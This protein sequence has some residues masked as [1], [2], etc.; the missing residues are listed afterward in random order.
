MLLR[1]ALPALLVS[2]LACGT[3]ESEPEDDDVQ[4]AEQ[5]STGADTS[6]DL[7][8]VS[9]LL[10][11]PP[12]EIGPSARGAASEPECVTVE[13]DGLTYAEVTFSDCL[14]AGGNL[15]VDG[16]VRADLSADALE[17]LV[18]DVTTTGLIVGQ[19]TVTGAWQVRDPF[20]PAAPMSW[21]GH[22]DITG[23]YGHTVSLATTASW[24]ND[25]ACTTLIE[26]D[27][28]YGLATV[29]AD[30]VHRCAGACADRGSVSVTFLGATLQWTYNG[31]GS[32]TVT[33]GR[34]KSFVMQLPC[35]M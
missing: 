27:G 34:D 28:S 2:A 19:A 11:A 8:Y 14:L 18:V 24:L 3:V 32:V 17:A 26:L 29:A 7:A 22:T 31:D 33:T 9:E 23:P 6:S 30:D 5:A 13:T 25:G 15:Y 16:M 21:D 20:A 1:L 35:S 12:A 4:T 10:A